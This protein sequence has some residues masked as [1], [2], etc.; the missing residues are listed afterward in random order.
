MTAF[1]NACLVALALV[2]SMA[3]A[4]AA[5]AQ[6]DDNRGT[7]KIH[8]S[9]VED[10][11][12]RNVPHVSCEFYVQGFNMKDPSGTI[13]FYSWPPTGDKSVVAAGGD[14]Q[15]W[16]GT[17]DGDGEY[18]FLKGPYTLA[19][20]HYR[21][22]VFTDDGHP[23]H[24]GHF[25]KAKMFWVDPCGGPLPPTPPTPP[26]E[27]ECPEDVSVTE[28]EETE[29]PFFP[30]FTSLALG[31]LGATAVVGLALRRRS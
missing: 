10:P 24:E 1:R 8:D 13:V 26:E 9:A 28:C 27:T 21:V 7:I 23:G 4:G 15:A 29:I 16:T 30:G 17:P 31:S 18:D 2:G 5:S 11:E 6:S 3:A 19:E 20:G 12:Q 22:E 14:T 25:A